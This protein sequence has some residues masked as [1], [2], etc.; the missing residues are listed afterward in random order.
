MTVLANSSIFNNPNHVPF[1]Y[2]KVVQSAL[3]PQDEDEFDLSQHDG[4]NLKFQMKNKIVA[5]YPNN[6]KESTVG[7][8]Y[9]Y[10]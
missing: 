5:S 2:Y 8:G 4:R 9:A 3:Q 10:T 1:F 7:M 6:Y